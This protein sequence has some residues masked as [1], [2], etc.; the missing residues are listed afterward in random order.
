MSGPP[1]G[2][3]NAF[4]ISEIVQWVDTALEQL[5]SP[6]P[7][8]AQ[9]SVLLTPQPGREGAAV[10]LLVAHVMHAERC[11]PYHAMVRAAHWG[12]DLHLKDVHLEALRVLGERAKITL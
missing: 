12:V 3:E 6:W 7:A 2:D 9:R 10:L 1:D 8:T 5:E 11:S 4:E